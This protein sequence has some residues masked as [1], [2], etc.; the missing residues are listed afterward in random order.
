MSFWITNDRG[1]ISCDVVPT[2]LESPQNWF[3]ISII[4]QFLDG[5][6]ETNVVSRR[7]PQPEFAT[8]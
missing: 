8:T 1:Q 5:F 4:R 6:D 7:T 3:R 2:Q